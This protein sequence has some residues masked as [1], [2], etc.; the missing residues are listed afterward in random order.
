MAPCVYIMVFCLACFV[1]WFPNILGMGTCTLVMWPCNVCDGLFSYHSHVSVC[2]LF[3]MSL[4]ILLPILLVQG[5][6]GFHHMH[7]GRCSLQFLVVIPG[8]LGLYLGK[9]FRVISSCLNRESVHIHSLGMGHKAIHVPSGCNLT[10][11][12]LSYKIPG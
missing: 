4:G 7:I 2:L 5:L 3:S 8:N 12:P 10:S 11:R 1:R 6:N 9:C